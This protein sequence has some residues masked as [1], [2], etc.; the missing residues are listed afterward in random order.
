MELNVFTR[1]QAQ[2]IATPTVSDLAR[3]HLDLQAGET[4]VIACERAIAAYLH[5]DERTLE[6][7]DRMLV[8]VGVLDGRP[9]ASAIE[10]MQQIEAVPSCSR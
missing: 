4:L 8:A 1:A 6:V 9:L 10:W 2:K 3:L 7:A 5:S